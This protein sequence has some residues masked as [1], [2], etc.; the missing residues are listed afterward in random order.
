MVQKPIYLCSCNF[1]IIKNLFITIFLIRRCTS[2]AIDVECASVCGWKSSGIVVLCLRVVID[3]L[4][5]PQKCSTNRSNSPVKRP[6]ICIS[7]NFKNVTKIFCCILFQPTMT[8]TAIHTIWI[9]AALTLNTVW[10]WART[11]TLANIRFRKCRF[12]SQLR[13][14]VEFVYRKRS[15]RGLITPT[16]LVRMARKS[17]CIWQH[18]KAQHIPNSIVATNQT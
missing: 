11:C 6:N 13:H 7:C 9:I 3:W 4:L 8:P 18:T 2:H 10:A 15:F 17:F 5:L 1:S 14:T 16:V 12:V